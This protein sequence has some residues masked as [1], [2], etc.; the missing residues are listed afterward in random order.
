MSLRGKKR[1]INHSC[2]FEF[3][4]VSSFT[5]SC[6]DI[7]FVECQVGSRVKGVISQTERRKIG[8]SASPS[9]KSEPMRPNHR[10]QN[11]KEISNNAKT[12]GNIMNKKSKAEERKDGKL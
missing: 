7:Y 1:L 11:G 4:F 8:K 3:C 6:S 5:V 12:N 9:S 10:D 2:S